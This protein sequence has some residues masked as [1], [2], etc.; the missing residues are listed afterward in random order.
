[1]TT[2]SVDVKDF[3]GMTLEDALKIGASRLERNGYKE[4]SPAEDQPAAASGGS[5]RLSFRVA[6]PP[7]TADEIIEHGSN[8]S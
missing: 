7:P 3:P 2:Q 5:W 6:D 1:M 8:E 4:I